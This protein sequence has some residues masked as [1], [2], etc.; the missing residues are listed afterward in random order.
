MKSSW[1]IKVKDVILFESLELI[2]SKLRKA[3]VIW[4]AI[5][6]GSRNLL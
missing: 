3:T 1:F 5:V 4:F 2:V 6:K